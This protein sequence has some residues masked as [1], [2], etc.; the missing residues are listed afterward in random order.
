MTRNKYLGNKIIKY[1]K[2]GKQM[3]RAHFQRKVNFSAAHNQEI[4]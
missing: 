3:A 4:F 2:A 1:K